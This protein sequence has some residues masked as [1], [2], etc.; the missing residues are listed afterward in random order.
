ML[1]AMALFSKMK[2]A[3]GR[4]EAFHRPMKTETDN[5]SKS[6]I[7]SLIEQFGNRRDG[8]SIAILARRTSFIGWSDFF[9]EV[10][11]GFA[12]NGAMVNRAQNLSSLCM[13]FFVF[14]LLVP[15]VFVQTSLGQTRQN[16][17]TKNKTSQKAASQKESQAIESPTKDLPSRKLLKEHGIEPTVQGIE[18]YFDSLLPLSLI[19]I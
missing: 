6:E 19:H 18:K 8:D 5:F 13:F 12:S 16:D 1:V 9:F 17:V 4:N 15:G 10:S 3:S 7:E 14:A 11:A 2:L